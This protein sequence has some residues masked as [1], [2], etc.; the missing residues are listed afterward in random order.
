[1][2]N[3]HAAFLSRPPSSIDSFV[4]VRFS[5]VRFSMTERDLLGVRLRPLKL[6]VDGRRLGI[7]EA[8]GVVPNRL[9][10]DEPKWPLLGRGDAGDVVNEL[11]DDAIF[12]GSI[13]AR[14]CSRTRLSWRR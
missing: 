9:A 14:N 5:G 1:M 4:S 2:I 13:E 6:S 12:D 7:G 8:G 11:A 3:F 10:K